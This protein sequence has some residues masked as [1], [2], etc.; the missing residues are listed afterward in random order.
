MRHC[1]QA[2]AMHDRDGTNGCTN[3]WKQEQ[4][5]QQAQVVWIYIDIWSYFI[6][7]LPNF[8]L[9]TFLFCEVYF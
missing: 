2:R 5:V 7:I 6:N 1:K 9:K 8:T 3:G 4:D